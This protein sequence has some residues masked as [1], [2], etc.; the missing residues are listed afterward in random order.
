MDV[1]RALMN[2]DPSPQVIMVTSVMDI[3]TIQEAMRLGACDYVAKPFNLVDVV[4]RVEKALLSRPARP[5]TGDA[6]D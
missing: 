2:R 1:L 5:A 4:E 3:D 6:A